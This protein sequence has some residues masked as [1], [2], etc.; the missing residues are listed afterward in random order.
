M[1]ENNSL[2]SLSQQFSERAKVWKWNKQV[3][4]TKVTLV[5]SLDKMRPQTTPSKEYLILMGLLIK[6]VSSNAS[7]KLRTPN[8]SIH[9]DSIRWIDIARDNKA[10]SR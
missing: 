2:E 6:D 10:R 1:A 9:Q 5:D 3:A 4:V 8:P 7:K